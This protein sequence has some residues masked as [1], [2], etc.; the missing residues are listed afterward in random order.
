MSA[1]LQQLTKPV[2]LEAAK[3]SCMR[4]PARG[5]RARTGVAAL[6]GGHHHVAGVQRVDVVGRER[7]A[8]LAARHWAL[9]RRLQDR[10]RLQHGPHHMPLLH[11]AST[12]L[13]RSDPCVQ[14]RA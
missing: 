11:P 12:N 8:L 2:P 7:G 10:R 6:D 13:T 4:G 9:V 1:E 14:H 5:A 3:K